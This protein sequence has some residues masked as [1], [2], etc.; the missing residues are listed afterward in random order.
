MFITVRFLLRVYG[1]V[2]EPTRYPDIRANRLDP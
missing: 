1:K 2:A